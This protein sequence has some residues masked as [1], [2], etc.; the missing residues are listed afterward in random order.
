M[1]LQP[2]RVPGKQDDTVSSCAHHLFLLSTVSE[3]TIWTSLTEVYITLMYTTVDFSKDFLSL[4]FCSLSCLVLKKGHKEIINPCRVSDRLIVL[5]LDNESTM[6]GDDLWKWTD[7]TGRRPHTS[8]DRR[9]TY[10]HRSLAL[11]SCWNHVLSFTNSC[12]R[13]V[14][15]QTAV[16]ERITV[17]WS[18]L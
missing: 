6:R 5:I 15:P 1:W 2:G 10:W 7:G 11:E 14:S 13:S 3:W 17:G 16:M 4:M 18:W 8:A 9:N 12:G